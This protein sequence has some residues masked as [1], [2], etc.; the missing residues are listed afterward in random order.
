MSEAQDL[1]KDIDAFLAETGMAA[2]TFGQKAVKNWKIVS[3]LKQGGNTGL[4]TAERLR[5]FMRDY[6]KG[7]STAA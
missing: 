4:R 1:I 5:Q 6:S 2:T 7:H 3:H